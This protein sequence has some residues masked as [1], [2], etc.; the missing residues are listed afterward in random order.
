MAFAETIKL[1]VRRA[2]HFHCCLCRALGVEVHH[3]V[4]QEEDGPDDLDNAAPLCP[5]CHETYGANPVKRKFI[6][7]ARDFWYEICAT[8]YAGDQGSLDEIRTRLNS[9]ATKDDLQNLII[10]AQGGPQAV[11]WDAL[12]YS[13]EREEFVHPLIVKE[14]IGWISDP[15]STIVAVDIARANRSNRFY[16]KYTVQ[17]QPPGS[18]L[19][20]WHGDDQV[21]EHLREKGAWF[22]YRLVA[23]SPSGVHMVECRDCGG[24]VG[25][26]GT[27]ALLV[28]ERDSCLQSFAA[29]DLSVGNRIVLKMLGAVHFGDRYQGEITFRDGKLIIGPD[30]GRMR[31]R[32]DS[33]VERIIEVR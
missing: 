14:L 11:P 16:G 12:K 33:A 13:F 29:D 19:V 23:V 8:R 15:G 5:S 32:P 21:L 10:K 28:F 30:Q 1:E 18:P 17:P 9:I 2:A 3:I 20:I 25:M 31:G 24:G 4:P 22:S 7:E 26:Y 6:R 27:V